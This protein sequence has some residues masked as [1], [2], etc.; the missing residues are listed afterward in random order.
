MKVKS[1]FALTALL[2]FV[3]LFNSC[4][5]STVRVLNSS[6]VSGT[7]RGILNLPLDNVKITIKD[8]SVSTSLDG[9]FTLPNVS[10]PCDIYL[11]DSIRKYEVLYKNV[12]TNNL[13]INLPIM[14]EITS[15]INYNLIVHHPALPP[16]QKGIILFMDDEKDIV[17]T[18]EIPGSNLSF[19]AK[20]GLSFKGKVF[21]LTY[22]KDNFQHIN[23][24][25]YFAMKSDVSITTG[26]ANEITFTQSDLLNVE[27][28]S[29][30]FVLNLP[31]GTSSS[32]AAYMLN[33][34]NRKM[35]GFVQSMS[36]DTYSAN[37]ISLL[38]PNNLPV[39]F[40]PVLY[41]SSV[42]TNGIANQ[43]KII[44]KTGTNVQINLPSS[45]A[46]IS[47]EDNA[48]NVDL[49]TVFSFQKQP[50]SNVLIFS[51]MDTVTG[52]SY[53]LC[54]NENNITLSLLSPMLTGLA[55]NRRYNYS[56][57]QVGVGSNNVGEFLRDGREIQYNSAKCNLRRF[58]SKP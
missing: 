33:F 17:G 32:Y 41:L 28:D 46:V 35:S 34:F 48:M 20:P 45:P 43:M 12:S 25:K 47:P 52:I 21:F 13:M 24:Y 51:I 19:M 22:T 9:K 39:D 30:S 37:N 7:V 29:L 26:N 5:D 38:M 15:L 50:I 3:V 58:T 55:S 8:V 54:T 40:T 10:M 16:E 57:E 6:T 49:S 1:I 23:D 42:N 14:W 56:I 27:E 18:G 53:N 2:L 31:Q 4:E 11:K 44:P 36:L